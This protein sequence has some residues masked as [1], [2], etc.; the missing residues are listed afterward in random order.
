[1]VKPNHPFIKYCIEQLP[2]YNKSL[3]LLG[4]HMHIMHST[5]PMFLTKMIK[6]YNLTNIYLLPS[7]DYAGDCTI[8][9]ENTCKGGTYFKHIIGF[10]WNS[11]DSM[12][13][14]YLMFFV[15]LLILVIKY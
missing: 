13:Y 15:L 7:K 14:K 11:Y 1:M 10:S 2:N 3:S 4:K 6:K 9:N 5:G 8:C 12:I